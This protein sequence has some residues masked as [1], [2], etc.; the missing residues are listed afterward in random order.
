MQTHTT[1]YFILYFCILIE[2]EL[3]E[4]E[5]QLHLALKKIKDLELKLKGI[6]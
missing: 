4:K 3:K 5:F 6:L 1:E 2:E